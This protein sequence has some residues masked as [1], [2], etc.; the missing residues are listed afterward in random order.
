MSTPYSFIE[1]GIASLGPVLDPGLC[2]DLYDRVLSDRGFSPEMFLSEEQ[3]HANPVRRH[4][5]PI[6][7]ERNLIERYDLVPG[8]QRFGATVFPHDLT[9]LADG[10]RLRY[11]ADADHVAEFP[12]HRIT[13]EAGDGYFW[14]SCVLHGTQLHTGELPRVSIRYIIQKDSSDSHTLL[15]QARLG[16]ES[17]GVLKKTR[18][19]V[20]ASGAY[21]ARTNVIAGSDSND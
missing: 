14:H 12:T 16:L 20:D 21:Q 9:I 6:Q 4:V 19:D 13:G 17:S 10:N 2:R 7:G 3:Y 1:D 15:D 18:V 5:N 8:S 11:R